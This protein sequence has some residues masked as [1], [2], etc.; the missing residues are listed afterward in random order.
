MLWV[1]K[2]TVSMRLQNCV[3]LN[4]CNYDFFLKN[5]H[6]PKYTGTVKYDSA[7]ISMRICPYK[8]SKNAIKI[9]LVG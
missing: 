1:L 3:Y 2:R 9:D 5:E 8:F 7:L 4:L 6:Q